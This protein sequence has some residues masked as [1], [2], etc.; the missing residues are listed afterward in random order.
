MIQ[1]SKILQSKSIPTVHGKSY[2]G[3]ADK[4]PESWEEKFDLVITS[5]PYFTAQSY[6]WDNWLREWLLGFDF[7][8]V[9]IQTT[10]TANE[11]KYSHA[12]Y[13][14][15]KESYRVLKPGKRAFIVVGDVAK[16]TSK[17]KITIQT[18][19]IIATEAKKIGFEIDLIIND[20]IPPTKRYNSSYLTT[21]QGL[22]IDRIVCLR[23]R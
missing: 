7:K 17:G 10:H 4:M 14:F 21:E 13:C 9:R 15:L 23:K 22:Q 1:K 2:L 19:N 20:D 18:S 12:M 8:E 6:P 11:E 3:K 16:K 5:P